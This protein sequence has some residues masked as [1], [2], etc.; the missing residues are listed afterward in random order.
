ME[1]LKQNSLK[2]SNLSVSID[3]ETYDPDTL[4]DNDVETD[5]DYLK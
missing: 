5:D 4:I 3:V 2:Q 1:K